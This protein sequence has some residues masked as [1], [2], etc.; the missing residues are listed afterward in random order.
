MTAINFDD[1]LELEESP[2]RGRI[3]SGLVL[4]ALI[5]AVAVGYWYFFMRDDTIS[6]NRETEEIP[7]TRGTINQNLSITGTAD[8]ELNSSLVFQSTGRIASVNVKTGDI[9]QAEQVLATLESE[10]LENAVAS[11]QAQVRAAQLQLADLLEGVDAAEFAQADQAVAQASAGLTKAE[12][13]YDTLIGGGTASD[14]AAAEQGVRAAEAQLATAQ[15]NRDLLNDSPSDADITAA[16][17]AVTAAES[18]LRSAENQAQTA[19]NGLASAEAG[20]KSAESAMCVAEVAE[21]T[22][23][24]PSFCA[25]RSAPISSGDASLMN[26][27]LAGANAIQASGVITANNGYLSAENGLDSAEASVESA[28]AALE[29]AEAR[30]SAAEDGPTA[31]D[32][33]AA[34]AAVTAA[35]AGVTAAR[36]KLALAQRGGTDAQKSTAAAAV[37]SADASLSAA[38]AA[39]DKALRGADANAVEQA[40]VAVQQAQLQVRAAEIRLKNS[41]IIAPFAGTIGDVNIKPGEF[42]SA[43][44]TAEEGGAIVL[45]TPD[46]L[47]L[48]MTVG[49]T[50]YRSVKVGQAGGAL[51]DGI[52]GSVYPFTITEI[53]L[54]PTVN[55]GVVTYDMK[56][57]IIILG[58]SPKPAPGM[59]ARGQ[60]ITE[61]KPDIL[62]I[63][64]RAIRTSGANQVVDRK[65]ADGSVE[66][67]IVTTG[68]TDQER[69]EVLTG[70][71]E[72]DI[73]LVVKLTSSVEE[74]EEADAEPTLPGGVR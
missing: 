45:L 32:K 7:V 27:A 35:Q 62:T 8:A 10:D 3:I 13:D 65:N 16:E 41:R 64:P 30:L 52:P 39:R 11:A 63:P 44:T 9:V 1:G 19:E 67:V 2:W 51:F 61:S 5:A 47:T 21:A 60:I 43:A 70:L 68:A 28:E 53:G 18:S 56:A 20:L 33:A 40:Q 71:N 22:I 58:D 14:L 37:I 26:S 59:N 34:D 4:L 36:E 50:D 66:E 23:S 24:S 55:N 31:G 42:F 29:S 46:R 69:V 48:T 6:I 38:Q 72:G 17:A 49:E 54:A 25:A 57:S 73:L 74:D 15:A 12:N